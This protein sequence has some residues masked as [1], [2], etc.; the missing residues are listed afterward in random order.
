MAEQIEL[1]TP[2][3]PPSVTS[4]KI[5]RLLF[6]I[7]GA[8]IVID[9][10]SNTGQ[11]IQCSYN[12]DEATKLMVAMN[13]INFTVTSMQKKILQKLIADA[14]LAGTISGSPD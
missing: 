8:G 7:A 2:I 14:K 3:V 12:G 9:L 4:Y 13:K 5:S 10:V 1:T 6:D 11:A